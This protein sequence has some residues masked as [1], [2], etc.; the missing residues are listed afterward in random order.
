[1]E[2]SAIYTSPEARLRLL[3]AVLG[4]SWCAILKLKYKGEPKEPSARSLV[5]TGMQDVVCWNVR[6]L[7]NTLLSALSEKFG[8]N[9]VLC[10]P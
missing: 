5:A 10:V 4:Q 6:Q 2:D 7:F 3:P 8:V 9:A 1:M